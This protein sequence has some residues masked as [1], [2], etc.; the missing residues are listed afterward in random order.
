M[1]DLGYDNING[2]KRVDCSS[3]EYRSLELL[4]Q[5]SLKV[6]LREP[7]LFHK[8]NILKTW[9]EREPTKSLSFGVES[10]LV[11]CSRGKC[12]VRCP[13]DVLTSNG[14]R[15]GKK[16][17][18]FRSEHSPGSVFVTDDDWCGHRSVLKN[19]EEHDV[20]RDLLLGDSGVWSTKWRYT[21]EFWDVELKAEVDLI[22]PERDIV[23]D[24]KTSKAVDEKSF[25]GSVETFGYDFQAAAY[26]HLLEQ[27]E[28][29][30]LQFFWVVAKNSPP[31]SVEVYEF[32]DD[33]RA[34]GHDKFERAI[35]EYLRRLENDDWKSETHGR[36]V[37][38][39]PPNWKD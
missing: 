4:N 6:L 14:Q 19:I 13:D 27:R 23:V 24:Y 37:V 30:R 25:I 35:D 16:F 15:R 26:L 22:L 38:A 32:G 29:R 18:E 12:V 28:G 1:I 7:E 8:Q 39:Q 3:E 34:R 5:S 21:P 2:T 9:R 33:Y 31:Y 11:V 10:E 17:D 36:T 20:A